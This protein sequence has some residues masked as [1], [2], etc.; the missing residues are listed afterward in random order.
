MQYPHLF[1]KGTIGH[2]EIRNRIVMPAMG[3][4]FAGTDGMVCDRNIQYYRER[5]RGGVGL[6]IVEAAYVHQSAKHRT[7]GIGSAEDRFIPG[8]RRL[9]Q[10]IRAEGSVP[11]IQIVHNGRMMSSKSSGLPLMAPSAIPHRMSG[12]TPREMTLED[13]QLMV[14]CFSAAASRAAEAGFEIVELHGAHGYLLQQFLSPYSNHRKDEYGGSFEN[15]T[16]FPLEVI[17]AVRGR[18]GRGFPILYRL[19][20]TELMGG[21][22]TTED[23]CKFAPLLE[24]EGID[25][26]H[27]SIG[28]NE[29]PFAMG[30]AIQPI[31]YEPGNLA[32]YARTI[33]EHV[34]IPVITVGRINSPE[35]AEAILARGDADFVAT[36][37]A[38]TADPQWPRKAME[39]RTE[40]IRQCVA[41]NMGCMGRL[42]QQLDVTCTQNPWVGTEFEAGIPIAAVKKR[43]LVLGGG[44]A[45]LEVA[46]VAAA[47]GHQVTLLERQ[48]DLGGQMHLACIPP[49]KTGLWE[50]VRA[51]VHDLKT[52]GV[53]VK[54]GVEVTP[55]VI[56]A[57][58]PDVVIEAIGAEAVDI[59]VPTEFPEKVMSAWPVLAGE[60]VPG[61]RVLVIGG[62]MVGLE[63][64]DFLAAR[65]KEVVVIE[66]LEELGPT[67]TP[68]ARATLLFRLEQARV[69]IITA[70]V[71]EHWGSEGVVLRR[72]DGTI[73]RVKDIENVVVAVGSRPN[74]LKL[75]ENASFLWK[76]VGDCE[77]PRDI[78]TDIREA[79]EVAMAL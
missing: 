36:G 55:A 13:V 51:R 26:L 78:L 39:G 41:C 76:R 3:T 69:E 61:Q 73:R 66:L 67:I 56:V 25:A 35:I 68:T 12:E 31:Y 60:Q 6:I 38:L 72:R 57:E 65:G 75:P 54:C 64:A 77:K 1:E 19:S 71:L 14:D 15:R 59:N 23:M 10:A 70:V 4:N 42:S 18:L 74:R 8:L 46:R 27:V 20:A 9:S 7:N 58:K 44:P 21:A 16:R 34:T 63:T 45:G 28:M 48:A 50:V 2:V 53:D 62:G 47:R 5:A 33:K 24:A 52:L 49:G 11:A 32:K 79:A 37:R 40:D 29:T 22:L 43:V 30:Q 17:R